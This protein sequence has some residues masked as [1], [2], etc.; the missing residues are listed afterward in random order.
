LK[1]SDHGGYQIQTGARSESISTG[2]F[3]CAR[4]RSFGKLED[5]LAESNTDGLDDDVNDC[6]EMM[7]MLMMMSMIALMVMSM[8]ASMVMSMIAAMI[9]VS[10]ERAS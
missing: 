6:L 4:S 2:C 5:L 10:M 7:L 3:D 9:M 8:I 1:G